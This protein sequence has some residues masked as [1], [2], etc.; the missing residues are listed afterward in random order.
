MATEKEEIIL[1]FKIE[2]NDIISQL[3]RTKKVIIGLKEE[4]K[5]LTKAYKEGDITLEEYAQDAV[6]LETQLKKVTA[7]H[8]ENTRAV[9]G[10]KNVLTELTKSNKALADQLGKTQGNVASFSKETKTAL[11][12]VNVAGV[13]VG[14]LTTKLSSF[15]NPATAA[16]AVVGALGAAY[17]RSTIG[18]KDLS[19][20]SNQLEAITTILTNKF[21]NLISSAEDG[22]GAFTKLLNLSGSFISSL[23][24]PL[25]AF[26]QGPIDD[27]LAK[28]KEIA[29]AQEKLDD[30]ARDE[31][32]VRGKIAERLEENQELLTE[33][34]DSQTS[35][36][37]QAEASQKIEDNLILNKTELLN[38]LQLQ[39]AE[40]AKQLAGDKE[41]EVLQRKSKELV[42][43]I[44][45]ESASLNKKISAND[46]LQSNINDKLIEEE[47][48]RKRLAQL[49]ALPADRGILG[50]IDLS[51]PR[52]IT[53]DS[54]KTQA[55]LAEQ[56][57]TKEIIEGT[58]QFEIDNKKYLNNALDTLETQ[59][60]QQSIAQK[61]QEVKTRNA[62]DQAAFNAASSIFVSLS[63]LA[64]DGSEEQKALALTGI[65]VDTAAALAG[66]ISSSQDI[67]YPGNLVAMASTIATILA[68]I[69]QAK[70]IAG[71]AEGGYTGPGYGRPDSSGFKPAGIVHENEYVAP[72]WIVNSSAGSYHVNALESM[73]LRG[74]AD[75]GLVTSS[76]TQDTNTAVAQ[77]NA[78]K[79][80]PA[81]VLSIVE[82]EKKAKRVRIKEDLSR[83]KR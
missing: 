62:L 17:A 3:E 11:Q 71:F 8:N 10:T 60:V 33:I 21:A 51:D 82:Y 18:A 49:D 20:A 29:L 42:A 69:A 81:P 38:I 76:A 23:A 28:S 32:E 75:G 77:M 25:G 66:G 14:D 37:R 47:K 55:Q 41:N 4:Q 43:Q 34:N 61:E 58:A 26:L 63:Q 57:R 54:E 24:G 56:E 79:N 6:R 80:L 22:E 46:R 39:S 83:L 12:N 72:K 64:K 9:A 74:Y 59:R 45:K 73:R 15:I 13:N 78:L 44:N 65:A 52:K 48:I 36:I 16:V 30:L 27:L 50:K 53:A 67:P 68:N 70:S 7:T 40:V 5:K 2:D 35:L 31:I 19:F 1:D